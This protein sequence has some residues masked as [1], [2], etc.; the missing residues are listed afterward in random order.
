M[1][2]PDLRVPYLSFVNG[3]C[4]GFT[5]LDVVVFLPNCKSRPLS[6]MDPTDFDTEMT[7]GEEEMVNQEVLNGFVDPK[8]LLQMDNLEIP[9][10]SSDDTPGTPDSAMEE[11]GLVDERRLFLPTGCCYDDRMKLH[12]NADFSANPSHPEDPRRIEVIMKAFK[13]GGLIYKGPNS[14]L[15]QILKDSPTRWMYRIAAR[16]ARKDEICTVHLGTHYDWVDDLSK[17]SGAELRQM[18]ASLDNGRRSLYVGNLTCDASLLAA[19]GAIETCK[20]VVAGKVK[21]AIAVIRP[22]GHHAEH[23]QA[24]GFC[25]FNNVPIAARVCQQDYPDTCRKVLIFDWDVHHGNGTQNM[26]YD[27]PNILYIS[28]HVYADGSFYPGRPEKDGVPDGNLDCVGKDRGL[29]KNVNIGWHSQDM[30]DAEYMAAFEKIVMPMAREFDPDLVIISAGFDAAAGD[31]LGGCWVTPA[32]YAQMTHQLM[33]LANGKLAVVLEGGYNLRAI[34]RSALAV[35]KTLMGE[36]P[37]RLT[38]GQ[39]HPEAMRVINRVKEFHAP[40]WECMRTGLLD[41]A[42]VTSADSTRLDKIV[43]AYQVNELATRHKMRP[44]SVLRE[45]LYKVFERQVLATK[46]LYTASKILVVIHD[47]PELLA[48]PDAKDTSLELHNAWLKDTVMPYINWA[49]ENKY[50]VIDIN[51]RMDGNRTDDRLA[52]NDRLDDEELQDLLKELLCFLWDNHLEISEATDIVLMGVG[53]SYMGIRQLLMNRGD[54]HA[55]QALCF[56]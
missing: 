47:P 12:A 13:D 33:S 27:D 44:I 14:E 46:Q 7:G 15:F 41:K 51:V 3:R 52:W 38:L 8:V 28:T 16:Y 31:E 42:D 55:F 37:E 20:N 9:I 25:I 30:G 1:A 21:N 2:G 34:S 24:M 43:R 36:P 5:P 19:G 50:G 32:C 18:S 4:I 54:A 39:P 17:K 45:R 10:S 22:P 56:R 11:Q 40:Y 49:V 35:A 29:G 23:D 6:N 53:N 48:Q 26:F